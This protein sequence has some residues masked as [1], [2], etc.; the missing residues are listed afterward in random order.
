MTTLRKYCFKFPLISLAV[1]GINLTVAYRAIA[2]QLQLTQNQDKTKP[3]LCK[4]TQL[5]YEEALFLRLS[6]SQ[7]GYKAGTINLYEENTVRLIAKGTAP[8]YYARVEDGTN[9]NG[10]EGWVNKSQLDCQ[11]KENEVKPAMCQI[12]GYNSGKLNLRAT[13]NGEI[14]ASLENSSQVRLLKSEDKFPWIYVRFTQV[15]NGQGRNKMNGIEGW[16]NSSYVTCHGDSSD[17][18]N[19]P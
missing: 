11:K 13:P 2:S 18:I 9:K 14:K 7:K 16:I 17:V 3:V 8:W 19:Y 12:E 5:G 15:N 1:L 10:L 4:A 6:K